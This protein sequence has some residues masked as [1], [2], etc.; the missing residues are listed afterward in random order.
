MEREVKVF[1]GERSVC[2]KAQGWKGWRVCE[3]DTEAET[4]R[5]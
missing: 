1:L 5:W 4:G 3:E 2:V